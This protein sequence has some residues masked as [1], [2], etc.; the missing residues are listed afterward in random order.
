MRSSRISFSHQKNLIESISLLSVDMG[1]ASSF[2]LIFAKPNLSSFDFFD[3]IWAVG[4]TDFILKYVTI[5]LKCFVL[6]LPKIALPF[7]SR[8]RK[9]CGLCVNQDSKTPTKTPTFRVRIFM[10]DA[11]L[12]CSRPGLKDQVVRSIRLSS[13]AF[14]PPYTNQ[15][16]HAPSTS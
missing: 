14:P 9:S 4:I 6:F 3:L 15:N 13:W 5:G 8:V 12:P 1:V 2:S 16:V 7:K 11:I 10:Y